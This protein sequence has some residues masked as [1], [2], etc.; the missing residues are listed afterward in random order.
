M[1]RG[2]GAALS[3][4]LLLASVTVA[5][6]RYFPPDFPVNWYG[7]HLSALKEPSLWKSSKNQRT[8]SYRFLWLRTFNHPIA[9]RID[10]NVD[11]TSLL[12]TKMTSGAGG[13][14]PG[15][16][17]QNDTATLTREETNR[18]LGQIEGHN[19]WRMPSI[20][21]TAGGPDGAHWIIEGV[22]D[23]TYH[24]VDRWSPEVGEIRSLGLFMVNDLAKMKLAA[25]EVY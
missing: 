8:Q 24:V 13:Y 25:K 7:K 19:F 2:F 18:F 23:G 4:A 17:I 15:T 9:I 20:E 3:I 21:E 16:L 12:T 14:E 5:Q 22:R 11:G 10:V 1:C 6:V